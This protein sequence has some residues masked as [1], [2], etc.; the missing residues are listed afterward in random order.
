MLVWKFSEEDC[1]I[2]EENNNLNIELKKSPRV[3]QKADLAVLS[4]IKMI[5]DITKSRKLQ[6][7]KHH[8][9]LK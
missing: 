9:G 3:E 6:K 7:Y 4:I 8:A 1:N 2:T 5:A